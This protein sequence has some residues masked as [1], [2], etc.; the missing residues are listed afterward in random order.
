MPNTFTFPSWVAMEPLRLLVNRLAIAGKFAANWNDEFKREFAVGETVTLKKPNRYTVTDG[1]ALATQPLQVQTTTV[2]LNQ[3]FHIGI[4][5]DDFEKVIEMERSTEQINRL[6]LE[7]VAEKLF[8]EVE[9]RAALFAY[10]N[11]PNVFGALGTN[12][13]AATPFMDA[14]DRLH[15]KSAP[16]TKLDV[17]VSSRMMSSFLAN[18]AVQFQPAQEIGEQYKTDIVGKAHGMTWHRSNSLYRHTAGTG[19]TAL[20]VTGAGQSGSSLSVT[21]TNGQTLKKGDAISIADVN[22][23]NPNTLR[24]PAGNQVQH[25][26]ITADVTLTAG[27]DIIGIFPAIVGPGSPFQNVDALPGNGAVITLWPGTTTPSG[28]AGTQGLLLAPNAFA[29]VGAKYEKPPNVQCS[30]AKDPTSGL[31]IRFTRQWDI[32]TAKTYSRWDMCIGFGVLYADEC[33]ARVVGA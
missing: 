8:Q 23:V 25:F 33:A 20:S 32:Q 19:V 6:Y 30:Y 12:P 22:F 2:S 14:H 26:L 3:P 17:F 13:T 11:T 1:L 7:P 21:G 18:Q 10:Q 29:I 24:V 28:K 9:S 15:D 16:D 4:E 31:S 27:P 5:W